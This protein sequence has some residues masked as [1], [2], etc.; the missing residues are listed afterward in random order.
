MKRSHAASITGS[1]RSAEA[2]A[3]EP[4]AEAEKRSAANSWRLLIA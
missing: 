3:D 1:S 2:A 4:A